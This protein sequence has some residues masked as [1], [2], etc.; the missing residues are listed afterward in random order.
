MDQ[1]RSWV[2]VFARFCAGNPSEYEALASDACA[3][4]SAFQKINFLRDIRSDYEERGRVYFP[5]YRF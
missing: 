5:G 3:L 2:D 1:P 4:G